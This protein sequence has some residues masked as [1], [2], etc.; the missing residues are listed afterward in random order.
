[1]VTK[2][3][4]SFPFDADLRDPDRIELFRLAERLCNRHMDAH[5]TSRAF[6]HRTE[7]TEARATYTV[8]CARAGVSSTGAV[9]A[10]KLPLLG[11]GA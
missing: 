1:M 9:L 8:A 11:D 10:V 5:P 6:V 3:E 4:I 7:Y 2:I